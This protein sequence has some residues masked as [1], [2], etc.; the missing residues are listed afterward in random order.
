MCAEEHVLGVINSP[1]WA[2]CGSYSTTVLLS[3]GASHASVALVA[4]QDCSLD[5]SVTYKI[6]HTFFFIYD[7]L[8]GLT[9]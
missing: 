6:S 3:G 9:V 8:L 7:P 5:G 2:G 4:K 1:H